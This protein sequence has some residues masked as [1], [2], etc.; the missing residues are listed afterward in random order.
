M[1]CCVA[2]RLVR[3][4]LILVVIALTLPCVGQVDADFVV[5]KTTGCGT[6]QV[7]FTDLSSSSAGSIVSWDWDLGGVSSNLQN[8]GRIF[9]DPGYYEVCLTVRD[10]QGN[11]AT[12]CRDSLIQLYALPTPDFVGAP[13]QGCAP[14]EVIFRDNSTSPNGN[15]VQRTWGLGGSAGVEIGGPDD[16][17][18][19]SVYDAIDQFTI[20]LVIEDERGCINTLTRDQYV[21]VGGIP[22][23][24][25]SFDDNGQCT[26]P[27]IVE[28]NV[29]GLS[30]D[31]S[32]TWDF[33]NGNVVDD[34]SSLVQTYALP[35]TYSVTVYA[36]DPV[37]MCRDTFYFNDLVQVGL[38]A[39]PV[40][41]DSSAC[42]DVPIQF[43]DLGL[44]GNFEY[45]WDFGDGETADTRAPRHRYSEPGCYWVSLTKRSGSCEETVTLSE[46]IQIE[47]VPDLQIAFNQKASCV[48]ADFILEMVVPGFDKVRWYVES[49]DSTYKGTVLSLSIDTF[50][51]VPFTVSA[52]STGGCV[53]RLSDT[54]FVGDV[55][56][57]LP[58]PGPSGCIPYESILDYEL[59]ADFEI[60]DHRWIIG[61]TPP[62]ILTS[63]NPVLTVDQVGAYDVTL[64]VTTKDDC[65]DS[66]TVPGYLL[67]GEPPDITFTA[68]PL[69]A[70][71]DTTVAF[72]NLTPGPLNS[73]Y[74]TFGD[75]GA[76][77]AINPTH[78]YTDTGFFTIT[79]EAESNG[80]YNVD[81]LVDYVFVAPPIAKFQSEFSCLDSIVRIQNNSI[82]ADL[83]L[84]T[85]YRDGVPIATS[86][87][88]EPE[89]GISGSAL[90][91]IVLQVWN[92]ST[93]CYDVHIDTISIA[94]VDPAFAIDETT[95]C[96]PFETSVSA[97][98]PDISDL[99]WISAGGSLSNKDSSA[100]VVRYVKKGIY[101][102]LYLAFT[103][104][105]GCRDTVNVP[106]EIIVS[107]PIAKF[108]DTPIVACPGA[109]ISISDQS[110]STIAPI[111]EF[112]WSI[113]DSS[114]LFS[115]PAIQLVADSIGFFDV[116]LQ[117]VDS[118]GC[119]GV[120]EVDSMII[121]D[122]FQVELDGDMQGCKNVD[123]KLRVE[124][125][126]SYL[127]YQWLVDGSVYAGKNATHMFAADGLY[128]VCVEIANLIGCQ[129]D[130]CAEIEISSPSAAF[131][132]DVTFSECPPL[133]V[134]F[135]NESQLATEYQWDFGDGS[136]ASFL[137]APSHLYTR[138]G[139]FDVS[140]IAGRSG[141]CFDTMLISELIVIEG[142]DGEILLEQL[143]NAC[144]PA[145]ILL[146][147]TATA[148]YQFIWDFGDG[149]ID[150]SAALVALD[151]VS[152]TYSSAGSYLPKLILVDNAQC[153]R[154]L[155]LADS[156]E[157]IG[158][159]DLTISGP[160]VICRDEQLTLEVVGSTGPDV[161]F[162]WTATTAQV[163]CDTCLTSVFDIDSSQWIQLESTNSAG[164]SS[165]DSIFVVVT[166]PPPVDIKES[167]VDVCEGDTLNLLVE[168]S[169]GTDLLWTLADGAANCLD[170]DSILI[171]P[172]VEGTI[173]V[174]A[175]DQNGCAN[176]DSV[177]IRV[178]RDTT[179]YLQDVTVCLGDDAIID[180]AGS[181][182]SGIQWFWPYDISCDTCA[183]VAVNAPLE[184]PLGLSA[185]NANGCQISDTA[186][187][188][189]TST[190]FASAGDDQTICFGEQA[191]LNAILNSGSGV[192]IPVGQYPGAMN[193]QYIVSPDSTMTF[194][195]EATL[196]QCTVLDSA[197]VEVLYK[198]EVDLVGDTLCQGD[199]IFL[200][201]QGSFDLLRLFDQAGSELNTNTDGSVSLSPAVTTSVVA[202]AYLSVCEPDTAG[203]T[204]VV[205]PSPLYTLPESAVVYPEELFEVPL[206]VTDP[207]SILITWEQ[208]WLLS[209]GNCARPVI[210]T[211]TS[212]LL[213]LVVADVLT[214]CSI[215]DSINLLVPGGCNEKFVFVPN[216]FSPNGDGIN[217]VLI[218]TSSKHSEMQSFQI[219]DRWGGLLFS[220]SD[221]G[222]GWDGQAASG[223][224]V[225]PGV[226][227]YALAVIC[228]IDGSLLTITG[229]VTVIR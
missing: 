36:T 98:N 106:E 202:I 187:I 213:N 220:T 70:C 82:G 62:T 95:G 71:S 132:A 221:W 139:M 9:A 188:G 40:I 51:V 150:S 130:T 24:D 154:T 129:V 158:S 209:C 7:Q 117:I 123:F 39:R 219:F 63:E 223:E 196:D 18:A 199:T 17:T 118:L 75:G 26:A 83:Q 32:Y 126:K 142:P 92:N 152:Y 101:Q 153:S 151:S 76:S 43:D 155:T 103:D 67:G 30:S 119:A 210:E 218:P 143:D 216:A 73:V 178:L 74:W 100:T 56:A 42:P 159:P 69:N 149:A 54:I 137:S 91:E 189:F 20:S 195:F 205:N 80:C 57:S 208:D 140:L 15:I 109:T 52:R 212:V 27:R 59:N 214:G 133:L 3:T 13:R 66:V 225:M 200:R 197:I 14:L 226:Y 65:V 48:P 28:F 21:T 1:P 211:D 58:L 11:S 185:I 37:S 10:D 204:I 61:T 194:M 72:S 19:S 193:P 120:Q 89:F 47:D 53:A 145:D 174:I 222:T 160:T 147:G 173:S 60:K 121:V 169:P 206:E 186:V 135:T 4:Y 93:G 207:S 87:L 125:P 168:T 16:L 224:Y 108:E 105:N 182:L 138:P 90:F 111:V 23:I 191:E 44:G 55:K 64:V 5:D 184:S 77:S 84:W 215:V 144:A 6:L 141:T 29:S 115:D 46:C 227:T 45:H 122:N 198:A 201:P 128:S 157:I 161:S 94:G 86:D 81:S 116:S 34:P 179:D 33:G 2:M 35:G 190:D 25:L 148:N 38:D 192:W 112:N 229:D 134:N 85:L 228:P 203:A 114:W 12:L 136:G 110:F 167:A 180:V 162:E 22:P 171:Y 88:V 78:V 217:D 172:E 146:V 79:L 176:S 163:Q 124:N 8:P 99:V 96:S 183:Q 156:I 166:D 113:G 97:L 177:L 41:V 131:S 175:T 164:C 165:V 170:C 68:D 49:N 181:D 50:G 104:E 102:D 107:R 127:E 31:I